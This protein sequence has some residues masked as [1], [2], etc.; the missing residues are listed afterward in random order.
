MNVQMLTQ[1]CSIMKQVDTKKEFEEDSEVP[2]FTNVPCDLDT[3]YQPRNTLPIVVPGAQQG[4]GQGIISI[5]DPRLGRGAKR[6]FDET[7]WILLD[8]TEWQIAQIHE[9]LNKMTGEMD[10]FE[11]WAFEGINRSEPVA[12]APYEINRMAS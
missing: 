2:L 12:V 9:I 6:Q 10:H 11:N 4:R 1:T 5:A 8:G 3:A 7:N